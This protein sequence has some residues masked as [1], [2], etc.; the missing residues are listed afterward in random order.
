MKD[1]TE[2]KESRIKDGTEVTLKLWSNVAGDSKDENNFPR[3]LLLS[4]TQVSKVHKTFANGSSGNIKL[5]KL[6][7]IK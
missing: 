3:K 7:C 6:I 5:S 1:G 2:I 4:N